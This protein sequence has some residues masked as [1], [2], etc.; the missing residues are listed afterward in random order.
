VNNGGS[1]KR[2]STSEDV[3]QRLRNLIIEGFYQP[4]DRLP[5]P[6]LMRELG[7]GRTPLREALSRLQSEGLVVIQPNQG[8]SVAPMS[9]ETLEEAQVLRLL[10][11][12]PMLE[13]GLPH[14]DKKLLRRARELLVRME[15]TAGESAAFVRAHRE[16]HA[17][18]RSG[19]TNQVIDDVV[20]RNYHHIHRH[21]Q[22]FRPRTASPEEFILLDR[23]TLDAIEAGDGTC[24]RQAFEFHLID[25]AL[26]LLLGEDPD[27]PL[28]L[29]IPV[30]A[31]IGLDLRIPEN[32]ARRPLELSWPQP[33]ATLPALETANL[34][35]EPSFPYDRI[36]SKGRPK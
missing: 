5:H 15:E 12:P 7:S 13:A 16:F 19:Y 30:A 3:Y 28:A 24:A 32:D 22:H 26:S 14:I 6:R 20:M 31:A 36:R 25:G 27:N 17:A 8:A 33:A 2:G 9:P 35:Y 29:L 18:M 21:H 4:N 34:K 10:I 11:E 1:V 23:V